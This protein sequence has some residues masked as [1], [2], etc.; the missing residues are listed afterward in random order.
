MYSRESIFG[1]FFFRHTGGGRARGRCD[2]CHTFFFL[3]RLPLSRIKTSENKCPE[4]DDLTLPSKSASDVAGIVGIS[5][6][7]GE[8]GCPLHRGQHHGLTVWSLEGL[9]EPGRDVS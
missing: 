5:T 7:Q 6:R 4:E 1:S 8:D 2:I 3:L 9:G